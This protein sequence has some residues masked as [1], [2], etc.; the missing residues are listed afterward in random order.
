[1]E[2]FIGFMKRFYFFLVE[3]SL[4]NYIKLHAF[5]ISLSRNAILNLKLQKFSTTNDSGTNLFLYKT[6]GLMAS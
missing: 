2:F 6:H 1:M 4:F 5:V 3:L